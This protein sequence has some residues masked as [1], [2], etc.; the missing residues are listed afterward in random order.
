MRHIRSTL[1]NS[2]QSTLQKV[3]K[4][5]AQKSRQSKLDQPEAE[6]TS[7]P[8]DFRIDVSAQRN[9]NLSQQP[10]VALSPLLLCLLP[11]LVAG[12]MRETRLLQQTL[13]FQ[14]SIR[15]GCLNTILHYLLRLGLQLYTRKHHLIYLRRLC[16]ATREKCNLTPAFPCRPHRPP[17]GHNNILR[18]PQRHRLL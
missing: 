15:Q 11:I 4:A 7:I 17:T 3:P 14:A 8:I 6:A 9:L 10:R 12:L 18:L 1:K 5:S 2:E 13:L 16:Y